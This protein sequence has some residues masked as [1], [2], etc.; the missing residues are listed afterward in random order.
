MRAC[1]GCAAPVV[2]LPA[3]VER[4]GDDLVPVHRDGRHGEGG[5][6]HGDRLGEG[7]EGTHE[8]P[9]WPVIKHQA[10]LNMGN[11]SFIL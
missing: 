9:E 4:G 6:K 1:L 3:R 5:D 8:G 7:D 2:F 10:N 11:M